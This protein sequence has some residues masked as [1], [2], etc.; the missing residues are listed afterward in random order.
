MVV[1]ADVSAPARVALH[2]RLAVGAD[3]CSRTSVFSGR[4]CVEPRKRH[5]LVQTYRIAMWTLINEVRL[6]KKLLDVS[7]ALHRNNDARNRSW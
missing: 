1:G 6:R 3:Q 2:R 4:F 5:Q 7:D